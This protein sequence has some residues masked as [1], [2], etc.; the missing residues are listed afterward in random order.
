[1]TCIKVNSSKI[2]TVDSFDGVS[3]SCRAQ[4]MDTPTIVFVHGLACNK[5][6]WDAQVAHFAPT[7]K[8]VTIDLAGHG[9]SGV[10]RKSWTMGNFAKDVSAVVEKLELDKVILVGHSMGGAVI[11]ETE[12]ILHDRVSALVGVDTFTYEQTYPKLPQ[13]AI[14]QV[15]TPLRA[16]F[17]EAMRGMVYQLFSVSAKADPHLVEKVAAEMATFPSEIMLAALEELLKWDLKVALQRVRTPIRCINSKNLSSEDATKRYADYFDVV[18]MPDVGHF[19]MMEDPGLFNQLLTE[20]V[21]E[22]VSP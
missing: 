22:L 17:S 12:K 10:G 14:D 8:V 13:E 5:T 16:N 2:G 21:Q 4:G 18:L 9:E 19:V 11:L 7:H 6:H 3:I 20:V 15:L 1:M